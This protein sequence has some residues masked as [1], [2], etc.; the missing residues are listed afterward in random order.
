MNG[1]CGPLVWGYK[2][3]VRLLLLGRSWLQV[4]YFFLFC[5]QLIS[6]LVLLYLAIFEIWLLDD[7]TELRH[8]CSWVLRHLLPVKSSR[9]FEPLWLAIYRYHSL[10]LFLV[11]INN[12]IFTSSVYFQVDRNARKIAGE[13]WYKKSWAWK[14]SNTEFPWLLLIASRY[15]AMG[16]LVFVSYEYR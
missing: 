12:Y 1:R 9:I 8:V 5:C 14:G 16:H 4:P 7:S 3:S 6:K 10:T 2:P 13:S 15:F 11:I